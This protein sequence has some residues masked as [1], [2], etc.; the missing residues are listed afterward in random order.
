MT[1]VKDSQTSGQNYFVLLSARALT[2]KKPLE[3][4]L[5]Q[6]LQHELWV[7]ACVGTSHTHTFHL[8]SF[9]TTNR[10]LQPLFQVWCDRATEK[11]TEKKFRLYRDEL[12]KKELVGQHGTG[13]NVTY[14]ITEAGKAEL[15]RRKS[16]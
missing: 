8:T 3:D 12:V 14:C 16:V 10:R 13:R 4:T 5:L 11:M 15:Q 2:E 9:R 6:R 1:L 7:S